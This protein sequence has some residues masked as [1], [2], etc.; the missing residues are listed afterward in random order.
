MNCQVVPGRVSS[1]GGES[2]HGAAARPAA[3]RGGE[4]G[5]GSGAGGAGERPPGQPGEP[6]DAAA[7]GAAGEAAQTLP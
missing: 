2:E 7:Q 3:Q 5:A 6:E 1:K 4:P